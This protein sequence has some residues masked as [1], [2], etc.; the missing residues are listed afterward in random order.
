MICSVK[1][2]GKPVAH[3]CKACKRT[4]CKEHWKEMIGDSYDIGICQECREANAERRT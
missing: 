2:C 1:K 4:W 3:I